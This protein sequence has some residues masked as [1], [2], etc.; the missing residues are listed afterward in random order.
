MVIQEKISLSALTTFQLGGSARYFV[1]VKSIPE[2]KEAVTFSKKESLPFFV[3]GEGSNTLVPDEGFAG[4][5]IKNEIRG[6]KMKEKKG[7]DGKFLIE[8]GAGENWDSF[9]ALTIFQKLYGLENLS[10]IPGSVGG[11]PVQ[12]IGAY[13]AEVKEVI[14]EVEVFDTKM[15]KTRLLPAKEC[16]FAYRD[17]IF[18][19]EAGRHLIITKVIFELGKKGR[20]NIGYKDLRAHF[21][22]RYSSAVLPGEVRDAVVAIRKKKLPDWKVTATAGSFFKNPFVSKAHFEKL[23][24]TYPEMPGFA[25][26]GKIKIPLAFILDKVCN[27]SKFRNGNVALYESQPLAVVNL[28]GA[29]FL[30]VKQFASLIAIKIKEK[31][32]IEAEWEVRVME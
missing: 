28:G 3:L 8:V 20:V 6:I 26:E 32:G 16:K 31:T 4:L 17:S 5:V 30:E 29:T 1:I 23:K 22:D 10:Y 24:K 11:A 13:G 18:K 19:R 14:T 27:L 7:E 2:L 21:K 15:M 25:E 9:V 12:N